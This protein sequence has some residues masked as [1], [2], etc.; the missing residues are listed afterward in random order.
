MN[1]R[2]QIKENK[3]PSM[4]SVII[5]FIF[6]FPIGFY[7]LYK[8]LTADKAA[9]SS[10]SKVKINYGTG[11]FLLGIVYVIM[12]LSDTIA[13]EDSIG[14]V[15]VV[16]ICMFILPGL[17]LIHLGDKLMKLHKCYISFVRLTDNKYSTSIDYIGEATHTRGSNVIGI[18]NQLQEYG[19]F[20]DALL[21]LS[22][23][24]IIFPSRRKVYIQVNSNVN[25]PQSDFKQKVVTCNS[26]GAKASVVVGRVAKCEYCDTLLS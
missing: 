16:I 4:W 24:E 12:F 11:L 26:C 15:I 6:F 5:A 1:K 17:Y 3:I 21:D 2:R 14:A 13:T 18:F 7:L 10:N 19:L 20:K 23:R 22:T 25:V 8:R 9:L